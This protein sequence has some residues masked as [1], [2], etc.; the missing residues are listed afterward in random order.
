MIGYDGLPNVYQKW[1]ICRAFSPPLCVVFK[2][3]ILVVVR[4]STLLSFV[5]RKGK[6]STAVRRF[7]K[8]Q[9]VKM[10]EISGGGILHS[11]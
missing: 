10:L 8:E 6:R 11:N 5:S 9:K 2:G 3:N 1:P 4:I 7:L